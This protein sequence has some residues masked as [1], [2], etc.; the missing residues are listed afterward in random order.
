MNTDNKFQR[1]LSAGA[2]GTA[3][4]YATALRFG[5]IFGIIAGFATAIMV[6]SPVKVTEL[7]VAGIKTIRYTPIK[8]KFDWQMLKSLKSEEF[9]NILIAI[10]LVVSSLVS[11]LMVFLIAERVFGWQTFEVPQTEKPIFMT[12]VA[13]GICECA[14]FAFCI[15]IFSLFA[16]ECN[17]NRKNKTSVAKFFG[18]MTVELGHDIYK[19][20]DSLG[21]KLIHIV[22]CFPDSGISNLLILE[23]AMFALPF[24]LVALTVMGCL[25][26]IITALD[27][28]FGAFVSLCF[29]ESVS[30]GFGAVAGTALQY[31]LFPSF[32]TTTYD[33]VQF[34]IFM[35]LG[36]LVGCGIYAIRQLLEEGDSPKPVTF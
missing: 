32:G 4:G 14:T 28:L 7:V 25:L 36:G 35:A 6:Y 31:A 26:I 5:I 34:V 17:K 11:Q 13:F 27:A 10:T 15:A 12:A 8:C 18:R 33:V 23:L 22:E 2:I 24:G 1:I 21:K 16:H 20:V 30:A 19:S 29:D 3:I 9:K